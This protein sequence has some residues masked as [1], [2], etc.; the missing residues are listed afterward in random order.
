[1]WPTTPQDTIRF[2]DERNLSP[3]AR[4]GD[5]EQD[6][7]TGTVDTLPRQPESF[8]F[9]KLAS[10]YP[11]GFGVEGAVDRG[12]GP[13]PRNRDPVRQ[14][15]PALGAASG[16]SSRTSNTISTAASVRPRPLT[17]GTMVADRRENSGLR[18]R[19]ESDWA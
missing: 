13:P 16:A 3:A 4:L 6:H 11:F 1:M 8:G 10:G 14:K 19:G 17:D 2:V 9:C 7:A 5:L 15:T 18:I 12:L